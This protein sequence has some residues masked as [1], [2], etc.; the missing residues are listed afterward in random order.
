M[1]MPSKPC[2]WC[3]SPKHWPYQCRLNE[4]ARKQIQKGKHAKLWS[5]FRRQ[6]FKDN[7]PNEQG[8]YECYLCGKWLRD[9]ETTLDHVIPRSRAPHLRYEST[10]LRPCCSTCNVEKGSKVLT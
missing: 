1:P 2:K 10:N 3:N 7:W 4:K 5:N 8:F 9:Y 6:W